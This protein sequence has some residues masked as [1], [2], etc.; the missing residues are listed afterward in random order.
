MDSHIHI[1]LSDLSRGSPGTHSQ[2][3]DTGEQLQHR[4][5][6]WTQYTVYMGEVNGVY[7]D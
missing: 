7:I 2:A 6:S 5:I 4:T 3:I 1:L